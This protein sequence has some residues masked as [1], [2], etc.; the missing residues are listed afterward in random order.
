M[1]KKIIHVGESNIGD[2]VKLRNGK[3]HQ[4]TGY[5]PDEELVITGGILM[6]NC[7][8]EYAYEALNQ[9]YNQNLDIV[10]IKHTKR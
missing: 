10:A 5:D 7:K 1:F 4:I 3:I 8:G 2:I 6:H 9:D